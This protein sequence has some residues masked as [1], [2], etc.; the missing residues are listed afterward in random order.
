MFQNYKKN[1]NLLLNVII[2]HLWLL[3]YSKKKYTA[4]SYFTTV[5]STNNFTS[6]IG[7]DIFL[8]RGSLFPEKRALKLSSLPWC[9][10][11]FF[12]C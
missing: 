11:N 2:V 9:I 6:V 5:V 12:H 7:E 3:Y 1:I 8:S 4:F 10:Y